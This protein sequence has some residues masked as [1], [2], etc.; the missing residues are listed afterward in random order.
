MLKNNLN[1]KIMRKEQDGRARAPKKVEIKA[2]AE[3]LKNGNGKMKADKTYLEEEIST[4]VL[5]KSKR[6]T[7]V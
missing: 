4:D 3:W 5:I 1:N 6:A 7:K 2:T